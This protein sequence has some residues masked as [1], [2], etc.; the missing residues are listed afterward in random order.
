MVYQC[1]KRWQGATPQSSEPC[2]NALAKPRDARDSSCRAARGWHCPL[3]CETGRPFSNFAVEI[4]RHSVPPS[5]WSGFYKFVHERPIQIKRHSIRPVQAAGCCKSSSVIAMAA[6]RAF[7]AGRDLDVGESLARLRRPCGKERQLL[8]ISISVLLIVS[9][10]LVL[11]ARFIQ[12][13]HNSTE[14]VVMLRTT[15]LSDDDGINGDI[16]RQAKKLIQR[17][18]QEKAHAAQEKKKGA[19]LVTKAERTC[20]IAEVSLALD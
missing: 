4:P 20:K 5:T 8:T 13:E 11:L 18:A 15:V 10:A 3:R 1:Q 2:S 17:A 16:N 7:D 14:S 6:R 9:C 19:D 12:N